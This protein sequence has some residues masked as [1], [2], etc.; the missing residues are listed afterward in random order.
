MSGIETADGPPRGLLPNGASTFQLEWKD[1]GRI[2][3]AVRCETGASDSVSLPA[4]LAACC[5]CTS[6]D[7]GRMQ[8]RNDV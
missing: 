2:S 5:C 6:Q 7:G 4:S 8:P 1:R 3:G